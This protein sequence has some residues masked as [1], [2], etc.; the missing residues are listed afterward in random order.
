[1]PPSRGR[2]LCAEP[3]EDTCRLLTMLLEQQGHEVRSAKTIRECRDLARRERFD[4][5]I[6]D[7]GYPDGSSYELSRELRKLYPDAPILFFTSAAF[8]RDRRLGAEA[9]ASAYLTKPG[10][11]L[12]IVE[13]VKALLQSYRVRA[14][15]EE[16]EGQKN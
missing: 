13:T 1:M 14:K 11:V 6:V 5:F 16:G 8:E 4:L 15:I 7:D 3:H 12:E 9:G 10:D 2:V